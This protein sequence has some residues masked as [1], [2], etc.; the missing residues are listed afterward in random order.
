LKKYI[1]PDFDSKLFSVNSYDET[2]DLF[3]FLDY[4]PLV[5]ARTH[6]VGGMEDTATFSSKETKRWIL[7]N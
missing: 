4:F 5:N 3:N 7:N 2:H 6:R 1:G